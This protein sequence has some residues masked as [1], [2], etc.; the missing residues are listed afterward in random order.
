MPTEHRTQCERVH[1]WLA[2]WQ[3]CWS[4][5][6]AAQPETKMKLRA[7]T[8]VESR[9]RLDVATA[10]APTK[11]NREPIVAVGYWKIATFPK[12]AGPDFKSARMR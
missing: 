10:T 5:Q 12:S 1:R 4:A 6:L 9:N 8:R 7:E 2:R 3:L 11:T